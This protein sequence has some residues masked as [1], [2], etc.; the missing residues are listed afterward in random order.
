MFK[1]FSKE[2]TAGKGSNMTDVK[3]EAEK[4]IFENESSDSLSQLKIQ[5]LWWAIWLVN[6]ESSRR[7]VCDVIGCEDMYGDRLCK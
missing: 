1:F 4:F 5:K 6:R 7:Y 2:N 3:A